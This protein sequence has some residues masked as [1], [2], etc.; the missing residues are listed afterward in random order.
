MFGAV[1]ASVASN[2]LVFAA[3]RLLQ[4]AGFGV[5]VVLMRSAVA[6]VCNPK[7]SAKAFSIA[8][9][10]VSL[11]SVVAPAIGGYVLKEWG[12]RS[13]FV[14]MAASGYSC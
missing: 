4:A 2:I 10:M 12:W 6:D 9:M 11:C 1:L 5:A 8:V 3:A 14:W 13:V 7:Q